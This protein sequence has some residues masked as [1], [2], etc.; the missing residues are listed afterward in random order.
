MTFGTWQRMTAMSEGMYDGKAIHFAFNV[1]DF[2]SA[3]AVMDAAHEAGQDVTLQTSVNVFK[4]L[5]KKEFRAFVKSYA[6]RM[7][8][9]AWLNLDHSRDEKLARAAVGLGWDSVMIDMSSR[10]IDENI[11]AVNRVYEYAHGDGRSALVEAEIGAVQGVEEDIVS[12]ESKI[13]S[14]AEIDKFMRE[15]RMDAIAVAFGNAHGIYKA[16]PILHYDLV[17]HVTRKYPVPF[18]VH[19]ASGMSDDT[20]RKLMGIKGVRKIN[21]STDLKFAYRRGGMDA[22]DDGLGDE[23]GFQPINV[24]R[25]AYDAM[26]ELVLS[27]MRLLEV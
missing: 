8:I 18:V 3:M 7:G 1:W 16:P 14:K 23:S 2:S 26:K 11:D 21:I 12:R 17:E 6:K 27:R 9:S 5:P 4:A 20:I 19:G 25:C 22:R 10:P 24:Q 13:A 15:A